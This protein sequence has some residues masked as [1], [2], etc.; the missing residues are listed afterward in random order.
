MEASQFYTWLTYHFIKNISVIH[1]VFLT[2][3]TK[4]SIS[5]TVL[6]FNSV[7]IMIYLC[8]FYCIIYWRNYNCFSSFNYEKDLPLNFCKS[9][10][11]NQSTWYWQRMVYGFKYMSNMQRKCWPS[12]FDPCHWHWHEDKICQW[13]STNR[14]QLGYW[15]WEVILIVCSLLKQI[16][17]EYRIQILKNLLQLHQT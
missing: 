4:L 12:L 2:R 14:F 7:Q 15:Y 5:L 16:L 17:L 8:F 3:R 1:Q 6:L 10:W 13:K 11:E 9:L